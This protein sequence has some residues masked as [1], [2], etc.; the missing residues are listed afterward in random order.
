MGGWVCLPLLSGQTNN[1]LAI[2]VENS[3]EVA[4]SLTKG[5]AHVLG[6]EYKWSSTVLLEPVL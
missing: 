4:L 5:H 3:R 1:R 2:P 6:Y